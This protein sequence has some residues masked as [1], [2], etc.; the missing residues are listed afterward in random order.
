MWSLREKMPEVIN[1]ISPQHSVEDIVVPL[2]QIPELMPELERLSQ[3]YDVLV[4]CFGHAGDGN[5]HATIVKRPETPEEEWQEA[6]PEVL[7]DLYQVVA[8][9]GGTISGEHG[10]GSKRPQYL[11]LVMDPVLIDVQ[12]RIKLVFD[13]QNLLNPGKIFPP[14]RLK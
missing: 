3:K 2:A 9:L 7:R 4:P 6:L 13:P 11:S 5:L 14:V 8:R 1:A 12:R 10:V